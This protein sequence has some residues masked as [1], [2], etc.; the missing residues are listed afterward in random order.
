MHSFARIR[1]ATKDDIFFIRSLEMDP[2][3]TM[4]HAWDA[5]THH[6][7]MDDPD[8]HYLIAEDIEGTPLGHAILLD[9]EPGRVEWRRIIVARRGDGIGKAFMKAVLEYFFTVHQ[10]KVI[11]LDVYERNSR[12]RHVYETLGFREVGEDLKT[13]PGE[14]LVIMECQHPQKVASQRGVTQ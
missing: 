14:R 3:N 9:N 5:P 10:A 11:W 1:K 13:V 7:N 6:T 4:V 8:Y 12:A 2:A